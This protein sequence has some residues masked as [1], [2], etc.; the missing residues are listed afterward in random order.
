VQ[1]VRLLQAA[2]VCVSGVERLSR[3]GRAEGLLARLAAGEAFVATLGGA[4]IEA[5][6]H[7]VRLEREAGEAARGGLAPLDLAAGT[8][9]V[10][11]GRFEIVADQPG[12]VVEA[13]RG[14]G[15]RLDP[16]DRAAVAAVPAAARPGLPLW[17]RRD[18][19]PAAP[20]LALGPVHDHLGYNGVRCRALCEERLA[21]ASGVM[22]REAHFGTNARMVHLPFPAY[23]EAGSKD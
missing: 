1:A 17:R 21:A 9:V 20:R 4:R 6:T 14:Q 19:E 12:L 18:E 15:A 11:D 2:A 7:E 22:S 3:P 13:L 16:R 10:W 23:L 5:G 8:P